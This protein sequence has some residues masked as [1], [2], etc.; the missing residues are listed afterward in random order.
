[1]HQMVSTPIILEVAP[2][3]NGHNNQGLLYKEIV[4]NA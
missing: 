3:F 2:K 4:L 1:M